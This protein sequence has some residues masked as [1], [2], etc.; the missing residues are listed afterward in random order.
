[1][2]ARSFSPCTRR[3]LS[4]VRGLGFTLIELLVVI[5]IIAILAGMLLPALGKAKAKGKTIS[6]LNN[7]RQIGMA[8]VLYTGDFDD[9]YHY[10]SNVTAVPMT[11]ANTLLDASTWPAALLKYL[12]AST[13]GVTVSRVATK[14]YVC[15]EVRNPTNQW[16]GYALD[17]R[18]SRHVLRDPGFSLPQPLRTAHM[19]NPAIHLV[20]SE[21]DTANGQYTLPA[22][23]F[24]SVRTGWNVP[25]ATGQFQRGG[26]VRHNWGTVITA[27]DGHSDW[28]RMPPFQANAP[29]PVSF[30]E[31][32]DCSTDRAGELWAPATTTKVYIRANS[33]AATGGF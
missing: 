11:T 29:A 32:G 16:G 3:E 21:K 4:I 22:A 13:G 14:A 25:D 24:N 9:K 6:C 1:M 8:S 27:A 17:Y 31:L 19:P 10:G 7:S 33:L 23:T 28:L 26:N 30:G 18:A 20:F 2:N 12:G 5:A 15:P